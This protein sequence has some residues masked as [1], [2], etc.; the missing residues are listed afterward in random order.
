VPPV[1]RL[2][3]FVVRDPRRPSSARHTAFLAVGRGVESL[4][5]HLAEGAVSLDAL[6]RL[7]WRSAAL[8]EPEVRSALEQVHAFRGGELVDLLAAR[9]EQRV[10]KEI[11]I[12]EPWVRPLEFPR[13]RLRE[14]ELAD[15]EIAELP[16]LL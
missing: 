14:H 7:R 12:A 8:H 1:C 3:G 10:R 13:P 4:Q 15:D 16:C 6:T 2:E 11:D 9:L 5:A